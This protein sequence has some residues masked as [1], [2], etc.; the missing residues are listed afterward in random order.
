MSR[1]LAH[2]PAKLHVSER[3]ETGGDHK[4]QDHAPRTPAD[5]ALVNSQQGVPKRDGEV[6]PG[7]EAGAKS[8]CGQFPKA[9]IYSA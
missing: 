3:G 8:G 9:S 4:P 6:P 1:L 2:L 5:E 7:E